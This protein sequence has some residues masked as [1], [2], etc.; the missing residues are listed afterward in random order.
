MDG[1][2]PPVSARVGPGIPVIPGPF[3]LMLAIR[4]ELLAREKVTPMAN[5]RTRALTNG[6]ESHTVT[7]REPGGKLRSRTFRDHDKAI[8]L[9]DFLDANNNSFAKAAEAKQAVDDH[10]PTVSEVVHWHLNSLRT[11]QD[12]TM[13]KYKSTV[14][15]RI[16]GHKIG[17]M[18][19]TSLK[20]KDV[21]DWLDNMVALGRSTGGVG[22]PVSRKTKANTHAILSAAL[23]HAADD[24]DHILTHNV[25]KRQLTV[26]KG[27]ARE[28]V[29]LSPDDLDM[30]ADETPIGYRLF[31]YTLGKTGLRYSEASALRRRDATVQDG[32]V[33]L[34][35]RRA[36]KDTRS[37]DGLVIGPPKTRKSR[38]NVA[39]SKPLSERLIE[40]MDGLAPDDLIFNRGGEP[41]TN[42]WFH[43]NIW[44]PL[45][46]R[47]V[48]EGRLERA[49]FIHEI[50][51]AHTT[52]LL[53]KGVP[54]HVV[55]S[56]LGH[57]DPQTTLRVY[58]R[59]TQ[60]DDI[61]AADALD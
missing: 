13:Q 30:L 50:R 47:L 31:V 60:A 44:Q 4:P 49:P 17:S 56:R 32:R 35:V 58:S 15:L 10:S 19:C 33:T 12:G 45:I 14:K 37:A 48:K 9:K 55:Q 53:Q 43:K 52:H 36:W 5:I 61:L 6:L 27:D 24:P 8:E 54:I 22:K 7:W 59:M 11:T 23:Q 1:S 51:H 20:A 26:D 3:A 46:K 16:D 28:P 40:H 41:I 39:C 42:S 21:A 29:Y 34:Q 18:P 38:R 25:A 57:E 2:N